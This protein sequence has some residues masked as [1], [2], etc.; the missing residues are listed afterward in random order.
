MALKYLALG[1]AGIAIIGI[2]AYVR[3]RK[4]KKT[5]KEISKDT[6]HIDDGKK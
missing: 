1:I 2:I 6:D 3:S 4:G 5:S